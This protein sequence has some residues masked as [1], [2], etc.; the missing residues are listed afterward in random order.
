MRWLVC[1]DCQLENTIEIGCEESGFTLF[2]IGV[3]A[4]LK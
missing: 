1:E 3:Q 2:S 4:A